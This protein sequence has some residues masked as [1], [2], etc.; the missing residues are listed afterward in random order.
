MPARALLLCL[1]IP[2][3][4]LA[5]GTAMAA[6]R[7]CLVLSDGRVCEY[8]WGK[9]AENT[10]PMHHPG[11]DCTIRGLLDHDNRF[12]RWLT[13][14]EVTRIDLE[15]HHGALALSGV[16]LVVLD[17]VRQAVCDPYEPALVEHVK[18]GGGLLV[19][20]GFFGL[21]GCAKTEYSVEQT[22]SSYQHSALGQVLPVEITATPDW[23]IVK[24]PVASTPV[25]TDAALG[26]GLAAPDW[27]I[28]ARHACRA[29]GEV[30]ATL[31]DLPLIVSGTLGRGHIIVYTGDDLGWVRAG[32]KSNWSPYAGTLWR[33]LAARAV[34]D[35]TPVAALA[36][37][38]PAWE[39]PAAF[40]HPDQPMNFQWGGAF[41]YRTPQME[42]LWARDLITHSATLYF[43][44]PE[45]L[46]KAGVQG[47]ESFG[48]PL[49]TEAAA[50]DQTTW[51]RDDTGQP[52][53]GLPCFSNPRALQY[54]DEAVA[55]RAGELAKMPWVVYGHMGDETEFGNCTCD[56]CR[57]AF[58][59]Q[60]GADLPEVKADFSPEYLDRWIDYCLFKNRM[61]GAMYG[62]AVKAARQANPRLT[63]MFA[64]LPQ[65]GGMAHGDDQYHTQA[66]F[67]LLW[68]HTYPGTMVIRTGLN[69]ALLEET[70]VLQQRPQVPIL[71]L[72]QGFDSYDRVSHMP[73][74]EY[75]R[76]MTWQAIAHGVDSIGWFVYNYCWW[77]LPGSEAWEE[78]GRLA[79]ELLEPL[80]PTLY[81]MRNSP[82][83][84]GLV[85]SYSQEAVDGLKELTWPDSEPWKPV[86]RWWT[87]HAS[88]EAYEVFKYAHVP[89]NMVSEYRL[90][91]GEPIAQK[92]LVFPY[93]EHLHAR[94]IAALKAF[95]ARGGIVYVGA[96][97]TL[98]LPGLRKL[99][100]SFDTNFNT[101]WPKDKREEWNQRRVRAYTISTFLQKAGQVREAFA[102]LL[103]DARVAIDDPEVVYNLR[104]AGVAK[105]LFLI[106]DHQVNPTT[107]EL[108][109]RRQQYNHFMLMPMEFPRAQAKVRL[110]GLR[111]FVYR[112]LRQAAP[113]AL[114]AGRTTR[115]ELKLKGGDGE[116][117]TVLPERIAKV[118]FTAKPVRTA[119]GVTVALRVLGDSGRPLPASVP[120]EITLWQGKTGP[121]QPTYA[122]TQQGVLKW[123]VPFLREFGR[124]PISVSVRD[125]LG[126]KGCASSTG[127]LSGQ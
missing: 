35:T 92:V 22:V 113:M 24:E 77:N 33:R 29:R 95:L 13:G 97:S 120:L 57:A 75:L 32:Q 50:K 5:G 117:L 122:T 98:D 59:K 108:R 101:W 30:L 46:G 48:C 104:E 66:G 74:P 63:R 9:Y 36:D 79:R 111:G 53:P 68:D 11:H 26:E 60:F 19:Y 43:N 112:G 31:G 124:E 67:D 65:T 37:P 7:T 115:L 52:L 114:A 116:L 73:P 80:T 109:K 1:L 126:G 70:A 123:T 2:L 25:L 41:Y 82:E 16:D 3:L 87:T 51:R 6:P 107:P 119:E 4:T 54:L 61:I 89:L 96:N 94:T 127:G 17:D 27:R 20:G 10:F 55:R 83:P 76:E 118:E 28:F 91:Q 106:N 62:R 88:Q 23:A 40:A 84:V 12:A 15:R 39:K 21:G 103:K 14:W 56:Y 49:A 81:E 72:L 85:W 86:I 64:S 34:A 121:V 38:A 90:M 125:L 8:A 44:A 93:V 58:R 45:A 18:A 42:E 71:D 99:P 110:Q 105:Y 69:A 47:W 100:V 78:C 102:P